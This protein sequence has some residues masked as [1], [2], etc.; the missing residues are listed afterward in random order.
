MGQR[1]GQPA[2]DHGE[3][4]DLGEAAWA[5]IP[6]PPAGV[7]C[8]TGDC[9]VLA[10]ELRVTRRSKLF[11]FAVALLAAL[12]AHAARPWTG[13]VSHVTDGDTLWVQPPSG[14]QPRKIRIDGID[15]PEIC[16]AWGPQARA[17]LSNL[18]LHQI[19]SVMPR[20]RDNY[21][22]IL[23]RIE[24]HGEDVGAWLVMHGA[25]WSYQFRRNPGPY[26]QLEQQARAQSIGLF[27]DPMAERPRSFRK[28]QG[29]CP[30]HPG[31]SEPSPITDR[32]RLHPRIKAGR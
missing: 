9:A 15:A 17:V 20:R 24:W 16:Q 19:V 18:L 6:D 23:A 21:G 12:N 3:D 28:R 1:H 2:A 14:A 26:P 11:L 7:A 32:G 22:R 27:A 4:F 25:A 29:S 31:S 8:S 5:V 30:Q 10:K 13:A